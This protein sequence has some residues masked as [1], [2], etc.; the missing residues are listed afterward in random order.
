MEIDALF[1]NFQCRRCIGC[2]FQDNGVIPGAADGFRCGSTG[3]GFRVKAGLGAF[4]KYAVPAATVNRAG[5]DGAGG[6][7]QVIVGRQW[8]AARTIFFHQEMAAQPFAPQGLVQWNVAQILD[9]ERMI[10]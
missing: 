5:G 3:V 7:D 9:R 6:N 2:A 10:A 8:I 1:G 4:G